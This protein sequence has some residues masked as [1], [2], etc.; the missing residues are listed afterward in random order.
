[1]YFIYLVNHW[2][3]SV[4]PIEGFCQSVLTSED[5]LSP[6]YSW[7]NLHTLHTYTNNWIQ[8]RDDIRELF[9]SSFQHPLFS[10][11]LF[12]CADKRQECPHGMFETSS[13]VSKGKHHASFSTSSSWTGTRDETQWKETIFG[14]DCSEVAGWNSDSDLD[15]QSWRK[16]VYVCVCA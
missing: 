11:L 16:Q 7:V 1:M 3:L 6:K 5:K 12:S 9:L 4:C 10:F 15:V 8:D 14:D 2:C 13:F